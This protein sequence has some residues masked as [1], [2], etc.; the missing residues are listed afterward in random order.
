MNIHQVMH[1]YQ[2]TLDYFKP[3]TIEYFLSQD[4]EYNDRKNVNRLFYAFIEM[5]PFPDLFEGMIRKIPPEE[6]IKK[7]IDRHIDEWKKIVTKV[8]AYEEEEEEGY[9]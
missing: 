7:I 4:Y 3:A 2:K 5:C 9:E 1:Y 8:C 6:C